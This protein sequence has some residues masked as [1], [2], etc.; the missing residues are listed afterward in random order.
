LTSLLE[1]DLR[2]PYQ[3]RD[4]NQ[5]QNYDL[6]STALQLTASGGGGVGDVVFIPVIVV[7]LIAVAVAGFVFIKYRQGLLSKD[8]GLLALHEDQKRPI[9]QAAKRYSPDFHP[10]A[11]E[12]QVSERTFLN[13]VKTLAEGGDEPGSGTLGTSST[14]GAHHVIAVPPIDDD[15][16]KMIVEVFQI[17]SRQ[18]HMKYAQMASFW[19]LKAECNGAAGGDDPKALTPSLWV[20]LASTYSFDE[21]KGVQLK[22]FQAM[23]IND[24]QLPQLH[25]RVQNAMK[26][27]APAGLRRASSSRTSLSPGAGSSPTSVKSASSP[28]SSPSTLSDLSTVI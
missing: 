18:G 20:S 17:F 6:V 2:A 21:N 7:C 24:P 15:S 1:A 4:Q 22:H 3:H 11:V 16:A 14:T 5:L 12:R 23:L 19:N 8:S 26:A 25:T 9:H 28:S 10:P 13:N 27:I